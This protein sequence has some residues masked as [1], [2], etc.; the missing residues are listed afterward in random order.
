MRRQLRL[1]CKGRTVDKNS[2]TKAAIGFPMGLCLGVILG[3]LI[4][5]MA[6]GILVG[7]ALGFGVWKVG[8][9]TS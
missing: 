2:R 3:A 9:K 6:I 5:N 4:D 8:G 1:I 7:L